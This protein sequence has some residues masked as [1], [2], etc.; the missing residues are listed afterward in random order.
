MLRR[1]LPYGLNGSVTGSIGCEQATW[2]AKRSLVSTQAPYSR[3]SHRGSMP[4]RKRFNKTT[5]QDVHT[6]LTS[7][8][9][10]IICT[11]EDVLPAR[12]DAGHEGA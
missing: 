2:I 12:I 7:T 5:R 4:N 11:P 1:F 9:E 3:L 6:R 8:V 10:A